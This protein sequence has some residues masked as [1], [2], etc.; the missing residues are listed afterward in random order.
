MLIVQESL[1]FEYSFRMLTQYGT[2]EAQHFPTW[3]ELLADFYDR[4]EEASRLAQEKT[5]L[6]RPVL[7]SRDRLAKKLQE[8]E[9]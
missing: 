3:S 1:P 8:Q 6:C 2:V 5:A 7:K 9:T 4:R